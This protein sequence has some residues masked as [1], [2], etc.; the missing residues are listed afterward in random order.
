[1]R[2]SL[3]YFLTLVM[4]SCVNSA[5]PEIK[6]TEWDSKNGGVWPIDIFPPKY[7]FDCSPG[8]SIDS[9][10]QDPILRETTYFLSSD[11]EPCSAVL[12]PGYIK[13]TKFNGF[14]RRVALVPSDEENSYA[15]LRDCCS[16]QQCKGC[17]TGGDKT[18][19][20]RVIS[21]ASGNGIMTKEKS[22]FKFQ[23]AAGKCKYCLQI[24]CQQTCD[25]GQVMMKKSQ[26]S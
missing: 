19:V 16:N 5:L 12:N 8:A 1:M 4:I 24:S 15:R 25:N 21:T 10:M 23:I 11:N 13:F 9:D 14:S 20:I 6:E 7:S 18:C 22:A 2:P 17:Y 26:P 3:P